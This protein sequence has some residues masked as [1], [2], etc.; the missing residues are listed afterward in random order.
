MRPFGKPCTWPRR[1]LF[2]VLV[3]SAFIMYNRAFSIMLVIIVLSSLELIFTKI[4]NNRRVINEFFKHYTLYKR[5]D[6]SED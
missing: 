1:A 5:K 6:H 3:V 2:F 4:D